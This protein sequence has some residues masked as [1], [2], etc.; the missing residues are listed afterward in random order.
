MSCKT[1]TSS[2]FFARAVGG[3]TR[4]VGLALLL[5]AGACALAE[6]PLEVPPGAIPVSPDLYMLPMGEDATGCPMF[7][8]WSPTL[9]VIQALHWRTAEGG[10][11]L[12]RD[13]ADCAPPE[14]G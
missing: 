4:H 8:A 5:F 13:A 2:T 11:T 6:K 7:Q 1:T 14:A 12:D 9:S 10:F 3:S